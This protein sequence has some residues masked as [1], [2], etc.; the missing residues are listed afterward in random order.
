MKRERTVNEYEGATTELEKTDEQSGLLELLGCRSR[1]GWEC[2]SMIPSRAEDWYNP[3]GTHKMVYLVFEREIEM[4]T[5]KMS[6][7]ETPLLAVGRSRLPPF[8]T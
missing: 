3:N 4:R 2:V 5:H 6:A 7:A 8:L 1:E